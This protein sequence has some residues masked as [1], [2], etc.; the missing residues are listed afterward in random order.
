MG[1]G[2]GERGVEEEE[3]VLYGPVAKEVEGVGSHEDLEV[4]SLG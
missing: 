2:G 1:G 4:G 3:G